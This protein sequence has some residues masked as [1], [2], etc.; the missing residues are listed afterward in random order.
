MQASTLQGV[1]IRVGGEWDPVPVHLQ[2][3]DVVHNCLAKRVVAKKLARYIFGQPLRVSGNGRWLRDARGQWS[4]PRFQ[5]VDFVELDNDPISKVV[6]DLQ[7]VASATPSP[8]NALTTLRE[9]RRSEG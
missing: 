6:A 2:D 8:K 9:L 4:I 1:V 7:Q 3:G 5:I